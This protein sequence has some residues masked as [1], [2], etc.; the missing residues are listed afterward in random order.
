M[1]SPDY[2]KTLDC[3]VVIPVYNRKKLIHRALQSVF[4]QSAPA[5]QVIVVD[6]GS[7]DGSCQ[8]LDA[9][10]PKVQVIQQ[11]RSGVSA[12]RNAAIRSSRCK[13]IAFLDSDD[14]WMPEKLQRQFA[15][16]QEHPDIRIVH[17]DEIWIRN[18]VRVNPKIKHAKS[19]GWIFPKCLPRCVI[20]PSAAVIEKSVFSELGLFDEELPVCEDYDMWLR[21]AHKY[22]VG[23]LDDKLVIKYGGHSDQLSK[24]YPAIDRYR[25]ASL[26][27]LLN[28]NTLTS[29]QRR[30][31]TDEMM[32]KIQ[33]YVNGAASRGKDAEVRR[34]EALAEQFRSDLTVEV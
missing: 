8:L 12:A 33:I 21:I 18:S 20:S 1:Q 5:A 3:T 27:K 30:L 10:Y 24:A 15:W 7:N 23:Y 28:T 22:P 32:R 4:D 19:G 26:L 2:C 34:Y 31:A 13:W 9:C 11:P 17:S 14:E 29:S 25:I 16:I 6:D